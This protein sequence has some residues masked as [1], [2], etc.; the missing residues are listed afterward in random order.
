MINDCRVFAFQNNEAQQRANVQIK[1]DS[2]RLCLSEA[3]EVACRMRG[4]SQSEYLTCVFV[5]MCV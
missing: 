2:E 1:C 4:C 5:C 3:R